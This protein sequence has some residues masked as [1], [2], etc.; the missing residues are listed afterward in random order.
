[1]LF[2]FPDWSICWY[3]AY[4]R[5]SSVH[6]CNI[7]SL[8]LSLMHI[9]IVSLFVSLHDKRNDFVRNFLFFNEPQRIIIKHRTSFHYYFSI[10][11]DASK[12]ALSGRRIFD[13]AVEKALTSHFDI[14]NLV[15]VTNRK[16]SNNK[17]DNMSTASSSATYHQQSND[18]ELTKWRRVGSVSGTNV[19]LDTIVWPGGD[20]VVSGT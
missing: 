2:H 3:S 5:A 6:I 4:N 10:I 17:T 13:G 12:L 1:M 8:P 20:I 19:H 9:N 15:P 18:T 7:H 14:L 16:L 11:R